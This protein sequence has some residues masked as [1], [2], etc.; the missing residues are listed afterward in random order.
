MPLPVAVVSSQSAAGAVRTAFSKMALWNNISSLCGLNFDCNILKIGQTLFVDYIQTGFGVFNNRS[1]FQMM[2]FGVSVISE[3]N[4]ILTLKKLE[5]VLP[6]PPAISVH[7][8]HQSSFCT[9]KV[10]TPLATT[11]YCFNQCHHYVLI[12][13]TFQ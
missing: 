10:D 3:R 9:N 12:C 2:L 1:Q 8:M 4:N 7:F 6:P 11:G 5:F 13:V